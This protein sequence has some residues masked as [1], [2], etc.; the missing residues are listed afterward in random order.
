MLTKAIL[1]MPE[2]RNACD[3]VKTKQKNAIVTIVEDGI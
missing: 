1:C 2:V 3:V